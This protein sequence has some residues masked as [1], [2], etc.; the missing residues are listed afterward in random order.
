MAQ[1][2]SSKSEIQTFRERVQLVDMQ[3]IQYAGEMAQFVTLLPWVN[4]V[5]KVLLFIHF[6]SSKD[7]I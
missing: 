3:I 4:K 1:V 6:R 5:F 2:A 7:L